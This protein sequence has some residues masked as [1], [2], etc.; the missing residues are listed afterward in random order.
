MDERMRFIA[1]L[2]DGE[3]MSRLC[4]EFGISRKTGYKIWNRYQ[5][6]GAYALVD[7]SRKPHRF[8]NQLPEQL[9]RTLVKIKREKPYWGAP[10]IREL[11]IRRF[12]NVRAPAVSTVHAVLARNGLV[13]CRTRRR[14]RAEGTP[15]SNSQNPNDLWSADFKGEFMLGDKR[16]CY[17]LTVSDHAS[18]YLLAI[19]ALDSVKERGCFPRIRENLS[20][21]GSAGS[22]PHGQRSPFCI[23]QRIVWTQSTGSLVAQAGNPNREDQARPSRAERKA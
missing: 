6:T 7:R 5:N 1:R 23:A 14:M 13:N 16:Y 22:D 2:L 3:S 17:P 4:E 10:K 15:L 9:E 8:G 18:R 12:P 19:E 11:L 20:R 21:V